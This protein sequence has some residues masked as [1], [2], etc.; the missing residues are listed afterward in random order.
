MPR[1]LSEMLPQKDESLASEQDPRDALFFSSPFPHFPVPSSSHQELLILLP[2]LL[3]V[4]K[5]DDSYPQPALSCSFLFI[6]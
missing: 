2:R 5:D 4:G 3:R 1:W 6:M